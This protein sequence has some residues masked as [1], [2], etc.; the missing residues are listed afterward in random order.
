VRLEPD[1]IGEFV[2]A[3]LADD[4]GIHV[5]D[6]QALAAIGER[7]HHHVDRARRQSGA[8]AFGPGTILRAIVVSARRSKGNIGRSMR[9]EPARRLGCRQDFVRARE[10]LVV[11]CGRAGR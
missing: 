1:A 3:F 5:G 10:R 9:I 7:L 11:E 8:Q 4:G 2:D 6:E